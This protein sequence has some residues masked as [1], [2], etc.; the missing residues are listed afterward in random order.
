MKISKKTVACILIIVVV[1]LVF[2]FLYVP[3]KGNWNLRQI[4]LLEPKD[5]FCFAAMGDNRDGDE[6]FK[7]I[8]SQLDEEYAFAIDA[9]DLVSEGHKS[10]YLNFYEMIQKS[11]IP[12]IAGIGNHD[13]KNLG[14]IYY[15][16]MFGEKSFSFNYSNVNFIFLDNSD[17]K[18]DDKRLLWLENELSKE[19]KLK[20]VIMHMPLTDPRE[21]ETHAMQ[22][23]SADKL[24][25]IL[26]QENVSLLIASHIHGYEE[27]NFDGIPFIITGGA[28][29]PLAK[30]SFHHFVKVCINEE[31]TWE[32]IRV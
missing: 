30:D 27:G 25:I 8:I 13:V 1:S 29:A 6:I 22:K 26:K 16:Q 32:V 20:I 3:V 28:G 21:G 5:E 12:F 24:M 14:W 10:E 19:Y 11:E 7:T 9:G 15:R 18:V 23:G 17:F 31:I 2:Y 4:A